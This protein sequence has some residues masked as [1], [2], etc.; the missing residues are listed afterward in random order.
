MIGLP[1]V[2][3]F[4]VSDDHLNFITEDNYLLRIDSEHCTIEAIDIDSILYYIDITNNKRIPT[5]QIDENRYRNDGCRLV[6]LEDVNYVAF[7]R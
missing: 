2:Q 6:Q 7:D 1:L 4:V 5:V 3:S